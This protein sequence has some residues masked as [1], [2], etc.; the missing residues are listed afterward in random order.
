MQLAVL[1]TSLFGIIGG[2]SVGKTS[3]INALAEEGHVTC[4]ETAT[5][6]I[7]IEQANGH[8]TPWN[9]E[10]FEVKV[11]D[12]KVRREEEAYKIAKEQGKSAIFVD[13]GLFDQ[14]V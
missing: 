8:P 14:L 1:A 12:E 7:L 4:R 5:D 13:R 3:I 6:F 2:S 10:G 11:F 9:D